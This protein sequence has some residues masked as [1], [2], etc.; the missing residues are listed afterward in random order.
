MVVRRAHAALAIVGWSAIACAG[1]STVG[2]G[3][4]DGGGGDGG[5]SGS[6]GGG[7]A[8]DAGAGG[9]SSAIPQDCTTARQTNSY[10]GCDYLVL[11]TSNEVH[12]AF[13]FAVIAANPTDAPADVEVTRDGGVVATATIAPGASKR[14]DLPWLPSLKG[15]WSMEWVDWYI[16]VQQSG[17][18]YRVS[19]TVP[20]SLYQ[21]NPL[22]FA[23][24]PKPEGCPSLATDPD[25]C[26]AASNDASLLLPTHVLGTEYYVA[27]LPTWRFS[28]DP[29]TP[30]VWQNRPGFVAIAAAEDG[31][32]V[33]VLST[34][35]IRPSSVSGV[36]A[37][38]ALIEPGASKKFTLQAGD[39]LLLFSDSPPDGPSPLP[40]KPCV[41]SMFA[42][43]CSS[44]DDYDLTGSRVVSTKPVAVVSGHVCT[45]IPYDVPACEHMEETLLP[46]SAWGQDA[47]VSAPLGVDGKTPAATLVR[48]FSGADEN[49]I[50]FDP[51]VH[52]PVE[53]AKGEWIEV[54]PLTEDFRVLGTNKL[55]VAQMSVGYEYLGGNN[56]GD[57]SLWIGVPTEQFR[58]NYQVFA[59]DTAASNYV[60]IV[61]TTAATVTIDGNVVTQA[62]EPIGGSGRAVARVPVAG[63]SHSLSS[64]EPFG[65]V[66]YGYSAYTSFA[67]PGGLDLEPITIV[68]R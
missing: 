55:Q 51:P 62:F 34:A 23:L 17:G 24:K 26:V 47:V 20:I 6:G 53:L 16:S 56:S 41:Q 7:G 58:R 39:L 11:Q 31:T 50:E 40:G 19:S 8:I 48:V 21:F 64:S 9:G 22:D 32:E 45:F 66:V 30:S 25:T 63:G 29:T 52:A 2:S 15:D 3:P 59:P 54:G 60:N 13:S 38:S 57:P 44:S 28:I 46:L 14:I 5:G 43:F 33:E 37:G 35:R 18:A 42:Q 1:G 65:V 67:Y 36:I 4:T 68:P 49:S 12:S 61:A 27:S 10:Y